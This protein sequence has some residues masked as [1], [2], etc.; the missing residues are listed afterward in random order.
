VEGTSRRKK[1]TLATHASKRVVST[2]RVKSRKVVSQNETYEEFDAEVFQSEPAFVR[3]SHGVTKN[4]GDYESLRIDVAVTMPCYKEKVE[5]VSAELGNYIA[6]LLE[7]E[8]DAYGV[9]LH[10]EE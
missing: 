10:G 8:L 5:E 4:I 9:S 6:V 3:V 2:T 7:R 1:Q